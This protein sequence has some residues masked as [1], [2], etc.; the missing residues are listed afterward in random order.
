MQK[1]DR[2]SAINTET[3]SLQLIGNALS[4]VMPVSYVRQQNLIGSAP[5]VYSNEHEIIAEELYGDV[6]DS[7]LMEFDLDGN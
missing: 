1:I 3:R 7:A 5:A 6:S 2:S 4:G